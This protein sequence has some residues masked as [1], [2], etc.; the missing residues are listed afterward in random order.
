M[1]DTFIHKVSDKGLMICLKMN[2][3]QRQ[4]LRLVTPFKMIFWL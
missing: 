3:G 2:S 4:I 1:S